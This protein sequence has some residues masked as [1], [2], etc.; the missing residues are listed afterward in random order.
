MREEGTTAQRL[1]RS[2]PFWVGI[3]IVSLL[4]GANLLKGVNLGSS[5][6]APG[7]VTRTFSLPPD[8]RLGITVEGAPKIQ[9]AQKALEELGIAFP[10]G[11][12]AE[13]GATRTELIVSNTPENMHLVRAYVD[14]LDY[15]RPRT[16]N[17][18]LYLFAMPVREADDLVR[19]CAGL[20]DHAPL[21]T[22]A[23]KLVEA[24]HAIQLANLSSA[25]KGGQRLKLSSGKSLAYVAFYD[26]D[27]EL[28]SP[29]MESLD[30][31]VVVELD[32]Q[33]GPDG[34]LIDV[35]C[36]IEADL[37]PPEIRKVDQINP[38]DGKVYQVES[39]Q[40]DRFTLSTAFTTV[41]G[42][43]RVIG[44]GP[45]SQQVKGP[46]NTVVVFFKAH[47]TKL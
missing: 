3:V 21:L 17:L 42:A 14:M 15:D 13:L 45:A 5:K 47:L 38:A 2:T 46:H 7:M 37:T 25:A 1:T 18:E 34:W 6:S 9:S 24:G 41:D 44:T 20:P 28:A 8:H 11:A 26:F 32:P 29:W 30:T 33:V 23:E 22:A 27:G 19:Q 10:E 35:N 40:T 39:V 4:L 36:A 12:S 43:T 31:G 16:V